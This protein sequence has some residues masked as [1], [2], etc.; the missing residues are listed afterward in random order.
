MRYPEAVATL[1]EL[2]RRPGTDDRVL[3]EGLGFVLRVGRV[4]D[5]EAL[6][7][8]YHE[9]ASAADKSLL[10]DALKKRQDAAANVRR[11]LREL[12]AA[13]MG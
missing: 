5:A 7:R 13:V 3:R 2:L 6:L 1:G 10:V 9:R 8:R 4:E 11:R 12:P